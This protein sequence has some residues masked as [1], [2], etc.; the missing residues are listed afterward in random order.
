M[1]HNAPS[2]RPQDHLHIDAV[3]PD[4]ATEPLRPAPNTESLRDLADFEDQWRQKHPLKA[5]A[6]L[7][8]REVY[9]NTAFLQAQ[10]AFNLSVFGESG[11]PYTAT[12]LAERQVAA[13]EIFPEGV[14]QNR[15]LEKAVNIDPV[16]GLSSRHAF[17]RAIFRVEADST[18]SKVAMDLDRFKS[19]NDIH[20][21]AAGDDGIRF[22]AGIITQAAE[23]DNISVRNI[24]RQG[25]DEF[26]VIIENDPDLSRAKA[27]IARIQDILTDTYSFRAK[28]DLP[29]ING[30]SK[31]VKVSDVKELGLGISAFCAST[32]KEADMQLTEYKR[33]RPPRAR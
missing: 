11:G 21:H 4:L 2:E 31:S 17:D 33:S 23:A 18:V 1:E 22:F 26:A 8:E 28:E 10:R 24:Y 13:N 30:V 19:L 16:S 7:A 14:A 15:D 3:D 32:Y 29:A 9:D 27:L 6:T 25:G 5:D 12:T 20:G